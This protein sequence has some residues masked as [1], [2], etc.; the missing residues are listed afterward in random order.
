MNTGIFCRGVLLGVMDKP[1]T[2]TDKKTQEIKNGIAHL[3]GVE[4]QYKGQFGEERTITEALRIPDELYKNPAFVTSIGGAIGAMI[5]V[6]LS[7]YQ[8]YPERRHFIT[9]DA[10][11]TICGSNLADLHAA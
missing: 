5:E 9:K 1:Y 3:M 6:P 8:D 7:G 10:Q 4:R 11:I 2:Y